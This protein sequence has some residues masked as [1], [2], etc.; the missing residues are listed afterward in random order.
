MKAKKPRT[1]KEKY[2]VILITVNIFQVQSA[3]LR[4]PCF[5]SHPYTSL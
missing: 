1:M 3:K 5:H 2:Q 4:I